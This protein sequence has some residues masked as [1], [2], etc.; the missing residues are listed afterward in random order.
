LVLARANFLK[1]GI[2]D[3][4]REDLRKFQEPQN[5]YERGRT[6]EL[7]GQGWVVI[8]PAVGWSASAE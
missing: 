8:E 6:F 2:A 4:S 5:K 3:P 7:R 1:E